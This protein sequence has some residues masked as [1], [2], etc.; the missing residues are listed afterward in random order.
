MKPCDII[1]NLMQKYGVNQ[2]EL[3]EALDVSRLSVNQLYNDRR[4]ITPDM[5]LRLEKVFGIEASSWMAMQAENDL[6]CARDYAGEDNK[7]RNVKKLK[8]PAGVK[9]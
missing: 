3:A 6:E 4:G 8:L 1:K 5:A 2:D 9:R 7:H